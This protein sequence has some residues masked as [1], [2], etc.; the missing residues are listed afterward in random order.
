[1]LD[2]AAG[3]L[4][5]LTPSQ[6]AGLAS[7][8][9]KAFGLSIDEASISVDRM[10]QAVN[11]FALDASELPLALGTASRGAGAPPVASRDAHLAGPVKNVVPGVER[12]STAVAVAMERMADPASNRRCA[13]SACR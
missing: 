1:V 13:A 12:A 3:S 6:A 5:Q 11:V 9:M 2:L 4:G 8:A 10:L 7:Q